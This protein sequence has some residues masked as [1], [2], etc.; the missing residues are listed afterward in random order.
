MTRLYRNSPLVFAGLYNFYDSLAVAGQP[1]LRVLY[2]IFAVSLICVVFTHRTS[3]PTVRQMSGLVALATLAVLPVALNST[4][5]PLSVAGDSM[6]LVTVGLAVAYGRSVVADTRAFGFGFWSF[7]GLSALGGLVAPLFPTQIGGRYEP[8][9]IVVIGTL[10][11]IVAVRQPS[12][13]RGFAIS[14]LLI[15]SAL[16]FFSGFRTT[17]ILVAV[18]IGILAYLQRGR[19]G[20]IRAIAVVLF[21]G[22]ISNLLGFNPLAPLFESQA[23]RL[24]SLAS[25]QVD[26]SI[27]SR[28]VEAQDVLD[29]AGEEWIL[30]QE[31]FGSGAGATYIPKRIL[32][33]QNVDELGRVHNIHIGPVLVLFRHGIIGL[34]LLVTVGRRVVR[35][36]KK[37]R[38]GIARGQLSR[39]SDG[40]IVVTVIM[41]GLY[42]VDFLVRNSSVNPGFALSVGCTLAFYA[43]AIEERQEERSSI[44]VRQ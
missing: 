11:A 3:V 37:T 31:L 29:T 15:F 32:I 39:T 30:G 27:F 5:Q 43:S 13:R 8:V 34:A 38:S 22:S 1:L 33:E 17:L 25:G 41:S 42:L 26:A 9:P 19:F 23:G 7:F 12:K 10:I 28:F 14:A 44:K 35:S 16:G 40:W 24:G 18:A 20:L 21:F 36:L 2:A 4:Y 6:V